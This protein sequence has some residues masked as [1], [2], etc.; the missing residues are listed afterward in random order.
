MM[1]HLKQKEK[2]RFENQDKRRKTMV[3]LLSKTFHRLS[4]I[5]V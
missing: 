4:M 1:I 3:K 5:K 2:R